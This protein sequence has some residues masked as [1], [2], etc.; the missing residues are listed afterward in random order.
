MTG[1]NDCEEQLE[2][3]TGKKL[4]EATFEYFCPNLKASHVFS[5][6]NDPQT[7]KHFYVIQEA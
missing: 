1:K 5:L 7:V 4:H 6:E 3:I 2:R